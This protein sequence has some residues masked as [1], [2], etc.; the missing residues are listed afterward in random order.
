MLVW[1]RGSVEGREVVI[2][3]NTKGASYDSVAITL[4]CKLASFYH[5]YIQPNS[6][7][8]VCVSVSLFLVHGHRLSG[9]GPNLACGIDP[10]TVRMVTES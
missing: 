1:L 3:F 8:S 9:S 2:T 5:L 10:Y 7:L 6:C 4:G